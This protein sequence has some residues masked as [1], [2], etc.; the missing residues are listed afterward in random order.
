MMAMVFNQVPSP[1]PLVFGV[2]LA[3]VSSQLFGLDSHYPHIGLHD[4][5]LPRFDG[6]CNPG[7]SIHSW[8]DLEHKGVQRC[9][10]CL[11]GYSIGPISALGPPGWGSAPFTHYRCIKCDPGLVIGELKGRSDYM[12][13]RCVPRVDD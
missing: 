12:Y 3:L 6:S 8:V 13:W 10:K 7:Y 9:I 4:I 1:F 11:P 5:Q 2:F